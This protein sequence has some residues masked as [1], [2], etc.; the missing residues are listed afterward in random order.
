MAK[1]HPFNFEGGEELSH[2]GATW[3]VS[4]AYYSIVD[5]SHR[6]WEKVKTSTSRRSIFN[7]TFKY[8]SFW[9]NQILKMDN[10]R[11]NTNSLGINANETKLMVKE[12]LTKIEG[13]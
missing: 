9:L 12:I 11:L 5:R 4:Y 10:T 13:R 6:T 7:R 1:C 2:M 8:H 3:F